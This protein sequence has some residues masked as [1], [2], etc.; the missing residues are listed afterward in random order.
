MLL[1]TTSTLTR[2]LACA[3]VSSDAPDN[4]AAPD[5]RRPDNATRQLGPYERRVISERTPR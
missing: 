4:A 2:D 1:A 5:T 3:I